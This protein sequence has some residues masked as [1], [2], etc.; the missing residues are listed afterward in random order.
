MESDKESLFSSPR[1]RRFVKFFLVGTVGWGLN[2]LLLYLFNLI[3]EQTAVKD[4]NVKVWFLTVNQGVIASILSMTVIIIFTFFINKVWTF[5]G[6]QFHSNTIFQFIQFL[7][8]GLVGFAI[9]TGLMMGLH[10]TLNWNEYL[11]M[12]IAFYAGLI[13]NFVWNELWTFNPKLI[14]KMKLRRDK[15]SY[16]EE[17]QE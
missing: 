12:V 13:S 7:L 9:Y 15:R 2:N 11:A 1:F 16:I 10:G 4:L 3:L 8:I 6:E 5:K 14:E 17:E